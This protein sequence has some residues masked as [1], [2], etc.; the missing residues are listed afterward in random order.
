MRFTNATAFTGLMLLT[1]ASESML[2]LRSIRVVLM[3]NDLQ[4]A[5]ARDRCIAFCALQSTYK[6]A[7]NS[8]RSI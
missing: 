8:G 6:D 1:L 7:K 2:A 4:Q 5:G 3:L